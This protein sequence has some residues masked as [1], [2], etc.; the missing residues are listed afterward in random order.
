MFC[1]FFERRWNMIKVETEIELTPCD[2]AKEF[3]KKTDSEQAEFMNELG[4]I[5]YESQG[6]GIAQIDYIMYNS[7]LNNKGRWFIKE[8]SDR[9]E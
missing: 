3:W 1:L 7:C 6:S 2:L 8:L 4:K 9:L 5:V